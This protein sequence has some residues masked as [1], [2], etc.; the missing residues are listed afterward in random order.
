VYNILFKTD[1]YVHIY[2]HED[3]RIF[4]IAVFER[5]STQKDRNTRIRK[6]INATIDDEP[7]IFKENQ[8]KQ[9]KLLA[10]KYK[11]FKGIPF[12]YKWESKARFRKTKKRVVIIKSD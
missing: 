8:W 4:S 5:A 11:F 12:L 1:R 6:P 9:A 7:F 3:Y 10:D 2:S